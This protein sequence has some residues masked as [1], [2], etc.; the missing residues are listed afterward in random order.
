M[1]R[2]GLMLLLLSQIVSAQGMDK[3]TLALDWYINPDHAP[4]LV[5]F[6]QGYFKQQ[7]LEVTLISPV[8]STEPAQLVAAGQADLGIDYQP[9]VLVEMAAGMPLIWVGTLVNQPL[10]CI[11]V[12][13][14]SPIHRLADLKGRSIGYSASPSTVAMLNSMLSFNHI[15]PNSVN[16]ISIQM[17]L[18][19]ALLSHR[20][21]AVDGMMRNVEPIQLQNMGYATRLFFPEENGVPSYDELVIIANKNTVNRSEV[22]RFNKALAEGVAYLQ[23]HPNLSWTQVSA[24]YKADL[25]PNAQMAAANKAIWLNSI[26][27]FDANPARLDAMRYQ[28]FEGFMLREGVLKQAIP[29]D[30]YK[31]G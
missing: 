3:I 5:A 12:L 17:D 30:A 28:K 29:I 9:S 15:A 14:N 23:A 10:N 2:I 24:N 1:K 19:Q 25:A 31:G 20:V 16:Q 8:Q 6:S 4:I 11:V 18:S 7:G 21:D 22:A 27:Y 13:A 26:Q